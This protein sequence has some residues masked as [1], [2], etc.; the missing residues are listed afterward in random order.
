M[1]LLNA[2]G[3]QTI[4]LRRTGAGAVMKLAVNSLIHGINQTLAEAV[5]HARGQDCPPRLAAAVEYAVF[6]GGARIS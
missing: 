2:M 5:R 3:K 6:P 4:C 1:P